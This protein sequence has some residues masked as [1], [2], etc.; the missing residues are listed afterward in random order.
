MPGQV[1]LHPDVGGGECCARQGVHLPQ[2]ALAAADISPAALTVARRNAARHNITHRLTLIESDLLSAFQPLASSFQL[3]A[4]SLSQIPHSALSGM[5]GQPPF[6]LITAN[7]PYIDSAELAQLPVSRYEP[8]LALDG[9]PG[10][11]R[12]VERL[13]RQ[14]PACLSPGGTLLLEIGAGQAAAAAALARAAFPAADI[15]VEP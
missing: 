1:G 4:S 3:P 8:R 10:G 12:L 2:A 7:L 6:D 5:A 9:G 15:R 11:L 13:L 14:A